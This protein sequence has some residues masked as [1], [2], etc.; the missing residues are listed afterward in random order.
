M[1]QNWLVVIDA[2]TK[3]PCI[4]PTSSVSTKATIDLL[5]EDFAHFGY[6]HS[7][8][9]DNATSFTPDELQNYCKER[10][11]VHL[12]GAPYYP[13]HHPNADNTPLNKCHRQK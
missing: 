2:Y 6:P 13:Y 11:I 1:G 9:S 12:T 7:I 4:H 8:V 5:E 3:Y 10:N